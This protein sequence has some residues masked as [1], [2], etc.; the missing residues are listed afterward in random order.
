M[1]LV[2]WLK[3]PD[4][5]VH[6][7]N[8]IAVLETSKALFEVEAEEEG[9]L[10]P[11]TDG[12]AMVSV[13]HPLAAL[14]DN[15][16][17][18]VDLS[19]LLA[20]APQTTEREGER[21]I[22]LKA[23]ALARRY[24]VDPTV[25]AKQGTITEQDIE[26]YVQQRE[27]KRAQEVPAAAAHRSA[28]SIVIV[29]GG[30]LGKKCI[31]LLRAGKRFETNARGTLNLLHA[32]C[33]NGITKFIYSSSIDVYSEPPEY[34]PVAENHPTRPQTH[35]GIGKLTGEL[36][37]NSY[38]NTIKVTILR[39]SIVCGRGGKPGGAASQFVKQATSNEPLT[40]YGD[41]E[42]SNDF[43]HVGD[44]VQANLLALEQD[45]PG[46]YNIGSGEE[47]SIKDLAQNIIKLTNSSSETVF[48]GEESNRPFRFALD[49]SRAQKVLGYKPSPLSQG[50][51]EYIEISQSHR[52]EQA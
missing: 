36:Y 4:D 51:S 7:G 8:I 28:S 39:Y 23:Q 52:G 1:R 43:V 38:A 25:L 22:T 17:Q 29:G 12:G 14:V 24:G 6:K 42:Q 32:A 18:E 40:I 21:K 13:G 27:A 5:W 3:N 34:L 45:K 41:G 26:T 10:K 50:L 16:K 30:G 9:Y 44:V 15:P 37:A 31:E 47:T 2:E 33:L 35:Y 20:E 49:I 48:T 11:L 19:K 46:I